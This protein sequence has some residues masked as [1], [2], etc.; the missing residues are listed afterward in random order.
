VPKKKQAVVRYPWVGEMLSVARE[1]AKREAAEIAEE[2]DV[3]Q[4][5][6]WRWENGFMIPRPSK[7]AAVSVAYKIPFDRLARAC[8]RAAV[9]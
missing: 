5:T 6:V 9:A 7:W 4:P 8:S 2:L 3:K 1:K